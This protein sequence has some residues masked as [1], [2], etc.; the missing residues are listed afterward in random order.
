MPYFGKWPE[1]INLYIESC[2]YNPTIDW[3]FF[4]D[5]GEPDNKAENVKY[6]SMSLD[7]I[8]RLISI[9]TGVRISLDNAYKLCDFKELYGMIFEDYTK[10]YDYFGFGDIDVIY[11]NI[12]KFVTDDIMEYDAISFNKNH[13]SGHFFLMK[14]IPKMINICFILPNIKP[15]SLWRWL[16]FKRNLRKSEYISLDESYLNHCLLENHNISCHFSES[17]NTPLSPHVKWVDGTF[18]FPKEWYFKNGKL[19]NDKDK[20]REFL[21]FHFMHWKGGRWARKYGNAQ[22]EKLDKLINFDFKD[23]ENGFKINEKGFFMI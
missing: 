2:K 10:G 14:N 18:L 21:Y 20:D 17:Y 15:L 8:S 16:T 22:W 1:W 6:V 23:A 3:I 12:R 11:G 7:E 19:T 5:C 13:V 4:T 9:K